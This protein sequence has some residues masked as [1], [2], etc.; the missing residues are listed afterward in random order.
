MSSTISLQNVCKTSYQG[1]IEVCAWDG[2]SLDVPKGQFLAVMGASGSG[3]STLLHLVA[4]LTRPTSGTVWLNG[5]VTHAMNDD[6]LADFRRQHIGLIFQAFNLLPTMT[7]LENVALP[8]LL[9]GKKRDE[10]HNDAAAFLDTVGLTPRAHHRPDEL[11]GGQQQRVAIARALANQAPILLADEPT[12][13]LDSKTGED[14]LH[15]LRQLVQT[16]G[17]TLVM[18]TH[19]PKAAAY[20]HCIITLKDGKVIDQ[21]YR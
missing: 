18:V 7:A 2:L 5:Q 16:H 20:A 1:K 8:L 13:N 21:V 10:A 3:K 19:D 14:I 17:R 12:G 15:L 11:S 4:G 9:L 6:Q